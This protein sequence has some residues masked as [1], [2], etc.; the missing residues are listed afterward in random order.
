MNRLSGWFAPEFA[1]D[2]PAVEW[3]W[4]QKVATVSFKNP[5]RDV[6]LFLE[7]D[8]FVDLPGAPQQV[9]V[10]CGDVKL[11]TFV[12][13]ARIPTPVRIPATAAQLGSG[14]MTELR[15]ELDRTFIPAKLTNAGSDTR[16]LGIRVF[17][18]HVEPR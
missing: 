16:D 17:H 1:P 14:E 5:K 13:D 6:T 7:Y 4:T 3:Q 8:A 15:I 18:V 12:A 10:F 9:S 2:D 11:A